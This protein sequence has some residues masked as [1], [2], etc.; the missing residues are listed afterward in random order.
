MIFF[1]MKFIL[2]YR[3]ATFLCSW[4]VEI[5]D[6]LVRQLAITLLEA[7]TLGKQNKKKLFI[8]NQLRKD[9]KGQTQGKDSTTPVT[10][11]VW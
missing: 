11:S 8:M 10:E 7:E 4:D 2:A 5:D 1:K 3:Y 6:S 9:T